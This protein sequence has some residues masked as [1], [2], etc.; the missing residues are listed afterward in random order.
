M[1]PMAHKNT[2]FNDS[3]SLS[4]LEGLQYLSYAL[5]VYG[6]YGK[7]VF[8]DHGYGIETRYAHLSKIFVDEGQTLSLGESIG[9]IGNTGRSTGKHLHYEIKINKKSMNPRPFLKE[10]Q[11]VS[12][13]Y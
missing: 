2:F 7:S 4:N 3:T 13:K 8:L 9:K 10:G 6:S 12:K 5:N 1:F 11:N